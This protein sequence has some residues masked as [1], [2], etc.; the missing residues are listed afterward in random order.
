MDIASKIRRALNS[1]SSKPLCQTK[2]EYGDV[3][4]FEN[5][6]LRVLSFDERFEQSTMA[7]STPSKPMHRYIRAMLISLAFHQPNNILH[8]GLGGGAL[9][10][11]CHKVNPLAKQT[12]IELRPGVKRLAEQYFLT[13]EFYS[14]QAHTTI[15]CDNA[16]RYIAGQSPGRFELIFSDIYMASGMD[17]SQKTN[18]YLANCAKLLTDDGWLAINYTQLP[19]FDDQCFT[20]L[21]QH[22]KTLLIASIDALNHIVL[23]GKKDLEKPLTAYASQVKALGEKLDVALLKEFKQLQHQQDFYN[24]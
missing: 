24:L 22:F 20:T 3:F 17:I 19:A 14:P 16:Q 13:E 6:G 21:N 8:L 10:R 5:K 18:R 2:D 4:V 9:L 23:A 7:I 11:A 12:A 1:F 15:L